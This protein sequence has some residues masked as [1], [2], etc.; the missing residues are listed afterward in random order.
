MLLQTDLSYYIVQ[1]LMMFCNYSLII[2]L[3]YMFPDHIFH[4]IKCNFA[5][6]IYCEREIAQWS[7][8]RVCFYLKHDINKLYCKS[9][10]IDKRSGLLPSGYLCSG[11]GKRWIVTK[12]KR[13][14]KKKLTEY[15]LIQ[16]KSNC[17]TNFDRYVIQFCSVLNV[18]QCI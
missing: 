4:E 2:S 7:H 3:C 16:C 17:R 15:F 1:N 6:M 14:R 11:L 13:K 8:L 10:E 9:V 18:D 5:S 12:R